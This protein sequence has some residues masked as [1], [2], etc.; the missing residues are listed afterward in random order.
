MIPRI[1]TIP[2][3]VPFK[4]KRHQFPV[5]LAFAITI[6]RC[7]GQTLIVIGIDLQENVFTHGQLYV[8]LSRTGNPKNQYILCQHKFTR[9][10]VYK[11][12]LTNEIN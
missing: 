11:E 4:Y 2:T 7:Q 6:N 8:A 1:P 5:K 3:D 10:I 9:N 12:I